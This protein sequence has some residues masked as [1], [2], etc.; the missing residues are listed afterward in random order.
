M[1][2]NNSKLIAYVFGPSRYMTST[3]E[4]TTVNGDN[5]FVSSVLTLLIR[6][7]LGSIFYQNLLIAP[8]KPIKKFS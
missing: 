6:V 7:I 2:D 1:S 4:Y 3:R 8:F 5:I